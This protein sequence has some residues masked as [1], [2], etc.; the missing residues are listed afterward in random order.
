VKKMRKL[1]VSMTVLGLALVLCN[2]A[3]AANTAQQTVTFEVSAI[4]EISA[5]G[6]PGNLVVNT[7]TAGSEPTDDV[8]NTTTWAV[9]TNGSNK[10]MTGAIGTDM[11]TNTTLE[12]NLTAPTGGSSSGDV[13]LTSTAAD[14][15]TGVSVIAQSGLS[16]TYTL[17]ATIAAGVV[18]QAQRTVTLTLTDG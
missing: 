15:V 9:T 3:I 16:I 13:P 18:A 12:V 6:N 8:D 10:K 4:N 1:M 14:L 2:L 11:P 5:S 7:A 17:S